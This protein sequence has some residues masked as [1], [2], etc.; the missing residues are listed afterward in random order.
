[1]LLLAR[2]GAMIG[3]EFDDSSRSGVARDLRLR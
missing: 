1:M 3:L 2:D